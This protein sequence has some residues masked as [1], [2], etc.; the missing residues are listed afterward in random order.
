MTATNTD[1]S[2]NTATCTFNVTV[3]QPQTIQ[4]NAASY[5]VP[6]SGSAINLIV[7][8]TGGSVGAATVDYATSD[9]TATQ[10]TD[11]TIKLGTLSF[12]D[13]ET[14][15]ILQVPIVNDVFVEG[16]QT[17]TVTLSNVTGT[18]VSLDSNSSAT[19]TIMDDDLSAPASNPID[20][21]EFFV[22]QHYLDFLNRV[23][24]NDGLNFWVDS[25]NSCGTDS[26]CTATKR[27]ITS[28]AFFLSIEFQDTGG[29]FIRTQRAA[30]GRKS[31]TPGTRVTY[32]ELVRA[33]SQI[34]DGVVI[35]QPGAAARL[36][37]NKQAYILQVV[38]SSA[39]L[40]LYGSLAASQYVD[41]LYASAGV[42][43]TPTE[44]SA[45]ITAFGG[46]GP[47]GRA[48]ALRLIVDSNSV[49]AAEFNASFVLMQ[50][51]GYLR[52]NPTDPPDNNDVGYQFWLAKLNAFNGDFLSAEMVKAFILSAEYRQRFGP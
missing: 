38:N 1:G 26:T 40:T 49:G 14:S 41:A 4:L 7:T 19:V 17:F 45:A 16:D 27:V 47:S 42:T 48:A 11:Y 22:R 36:E 20:G 39:F 52:R 5:N 33:Q 21:T 10:K 23:P 46:G 51:F 32:L 34:G 9:G 6:E 3:N 24:D 43:P 50:Y 13:G 15:K 29:F 8:R 12:A 37:A 2:G 31:D 30:F 18:G 28:G 44:R 25:I 35:G